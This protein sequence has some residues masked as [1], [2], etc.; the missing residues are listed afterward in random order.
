MMVG[1][2]NQFKW[3]L[4]AVIGVNQSPYTEMAHATVTNF[5]RFGIHVAFEAYMDTDATE[6]EIKQALRVVRDRARSERT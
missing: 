2:F 4:C 1:Y 5:K 6:E 3:T